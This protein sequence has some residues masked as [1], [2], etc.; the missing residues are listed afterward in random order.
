M[1]KPKEFE[2]LPETNE[3]ITEATEAL[4]ENDGEAEKGICI[5]TPHGN[6]ALTKSELERIIKELE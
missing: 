3:L 4:F 1:S 2:W 6:I 5:I